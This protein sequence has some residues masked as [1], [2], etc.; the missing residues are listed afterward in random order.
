MYSQPIS[1]LCILFLICTGT[2][3]EHGSS[4]SFTISSTALIFHEYNLTIPLYRFPL[5]PM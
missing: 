5:L 2:Q 4:P 1:R 3:E